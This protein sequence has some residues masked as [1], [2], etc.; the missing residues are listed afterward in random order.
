MPKLNEEGSGE[1]AF[2]AIVEKIFQETDIRSVVV[3]NRFINAF[4]KKSGSLFAEL[5]R[6]RKKSGGFGVKRTHKQ[7]AR[8]VVFIQ[9]SAF[10]SIELPKLNEEGSGESA[11]AAIVEKIFQETGIRSVVVKNRI[12]NAFRKKSGSLFAEL[13]RVKKKSGGFGVKRTHKQMA[14]PNFNMR[15]AKIFYHELDKYIIEKEN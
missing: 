12:I 15:S 10:S 14:R 8:T 7:M 5:K 2:A 4:R 6:V 11:F 1:S 13:K 3:K 9:L